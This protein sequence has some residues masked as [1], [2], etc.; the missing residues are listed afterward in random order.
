[1]RNYF[2]LDVWKESHTFT[3]AIYQTT[4]SFSDTERF[5]LVSQMRRAAT[6][7]SANIAEG[8]GR[9]GHSAFARFLHRAAGSASE[10]AYY[11]LLARDLAYLDDASYRVLSEQVIRIKKMLVALARKSTK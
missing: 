2:Q 6:S 9:H 1:M 11:L 7:I 10:T 3:L 8:A 5:G 4:R